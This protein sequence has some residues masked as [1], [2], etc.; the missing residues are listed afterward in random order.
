MFLIHTINVEWDRKDAKIIVH[1]P[2]V[3]C[4]SSLTCKVMTDWVADRH[5]ISKIAFNPRCRSV[6]MQIQ[7]QISG[8]TAL[9][10]R[11]HR[12]SDQLMSMYTELQQM[13][14][15]GN[16]NVRKVLPQCADDLMHWLHW[17][18]LAFQFVCISMYQCLTVCPSLTSYKDGAVIN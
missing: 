10:W 11:S 2:K 13:P 18:L 6:A 14:W 7:R 3:T 16:E 4:Q 17:H 8:R 1:C 9:M 12:A 15:A 5:K